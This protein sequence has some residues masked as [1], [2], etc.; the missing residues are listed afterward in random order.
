MF[1]VYLHC[2]QNTVVSKTDNPIYFNCIK[3]KCEDTSGIAC[4]EVIFKRRYNDNDIMTA[5]KLP[6]Y[7]PYKISI[8]LLD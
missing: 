6:L 2:P 8:N 5:N 7:S 4:C 3:E 1:P